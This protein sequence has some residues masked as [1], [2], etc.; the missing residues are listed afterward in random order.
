MRECFVSTIA[1]RGQFAVL[2]CVLR[3]WH[4]INAD[5]DI[6]VRAVPGPARFPIVIVDPTPH[7]AALP[8]VKD[9]RTTILCYTQDHVHCR[10]IREV[11][12][13]QPNTGESPP[14]NRYIRSRLLLLL[15]M[16]RRRLIYFL[17]LFHSFSKDGP[18]NCLHLPKRVDSMLF[19]REKI[20]KKLVMSPF[21]DLICCNSY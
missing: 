7:L 6:V 12:L 14:T 21:V 3:G 10:D 8:H 1:I 18:L 16:Q 5:P 15:V 19:F 11:R 17:C 9:G 13:R 20:S 4:P 2:S